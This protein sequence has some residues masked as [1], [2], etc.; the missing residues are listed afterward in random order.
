MIDEPQH[1]PRT[2]FALDG[3][4]AFFSIIC[5]C[6][7]RRAAAFASSR[8]SRRRVARLMNGGVGVPVAVADAFCT[9]GSIVAVGFC[10]ASCG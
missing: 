5:V 7:A 6:L 2:A 9:V 3:S 10:V 8:A 1:R 4:E